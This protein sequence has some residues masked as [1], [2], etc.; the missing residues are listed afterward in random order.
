MKLS[1]QDADLFFKL[2]WSLQNFVNQRL[3]IISE[4]TTID[5]YQK[6]PSSKKLI[7]REALYEKIEL[8]D[9]Y[10]EENH[11]RLSGEEFS[12]IESWKNFQ[13]GDYFIERLLKNHAIFIRENEVYAVQALYESFDDVL[14]FISLPYYAHAVLL[15]FKGRIIYD[16]L[17]QGYAISFGG[18]IRQTLKETYMTAKQSGRII[19]S[20]DP[21]KR[22]EGMIASEKAVKDF[23][24]TIDEILQQVKKLR[25]SSHA[26]AIQSPAF[27]MVK[28]S[29]EFAQSAVENPDEID[30]LW[31]ALK[32]VQ[33]AIKRAETVLNRS[34]YY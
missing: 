15:P 4:A 30:H 2:M 24:P 22:A 21:E 13:R 20:F 14:P 33:R 9:A 26:P 29:I 23:G 8:I 28:A 31:I 12:I 16:G 32:K 34:Q 18:G 3:G 10:L 17:L 11:Q 6:L 7:V 19:A 27:N 5:E 25:S 1:K